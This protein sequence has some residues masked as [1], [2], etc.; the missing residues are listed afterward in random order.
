MLLTAAIIALLA[1][2]ALFQLVPREGRSMAFLDGFTF[3]TII[4]LFVFSI[5]PDAIAQA[6]PLAWVFAVLGLGFPLL[7]ERLF[8]ASL[9]KAHLLIVGLAV[10]GLALHAIIDGVVLLGGEDGGGHGHGHGHGHRHDGH[11][12]ESLA[13][14]VILHN[15]PKG[16]AI[17]YLMMPAFGLLR[18]ALV[19]ALLVAGTVAGYLLGDELLASF[20]V[21]AVAAFQA[22]VAGSILHVVL[23]G[24]A[25]H[26]HDHDH[27]PRPAA[28]KWP[29]RLGLASGIVLL[30]FYL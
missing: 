25:V 27:Q 23:H 7:V 1:G 30:Y 22:F 14:A 13:I 24:A 10:A 8:A 2:P 20:S 28:D 3:I 29:E 16:L 6:G 18:S 26:A 12:E 21:T 19:F 17:W 11:A 5:L 15:I 9:N 4:G